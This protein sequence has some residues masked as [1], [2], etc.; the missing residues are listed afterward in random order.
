[1]ANAQTVQAV[2]V[3][4]LLYLFYGG[5]QVN[6]HRTTIKLGRAWPFFDWGPP[7]ERRKHVRMVR[8]DQMW[9]H[10]Q[11]TDEQVIGQLV[12]Y[13]EAHEATLTALPGGKS[14]WNNLSSP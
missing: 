7:Q 10:E 6:G 4:C 11:L 12:R 1:M 9:T 13:G 8:T 3:L 5:K 2:W 14:T